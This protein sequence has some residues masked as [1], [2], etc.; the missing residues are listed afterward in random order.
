MRAPKNV[1]A[2]LCHSEMSLAGSQAASPYSVSAASAAKNPHAHGMVP[3]IGS[4]NTCCHVPLAVLENLEKSAMLTATVHH[5]ST[6]KLSTPAR[7]NERPD[8]NGD[9][10]GWTNNRLES[11]KVLELGDGDHGDGRLD[12]PVDEEAQQTARGDVGRI[13]Q[14]I[15]HI[16]KARR[17]RDEQLLGEAATRQ[18]ED[19]EPHE[20]EERTC[21]DGK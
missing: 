9:E 21:S 3:V 2:R 17:Q 8:T 20:C 19:A 7:L 13:R 16:G 15:G 11:E 10:S 12:K 18:G 14:V 6:H 5:W 4:S 1:H